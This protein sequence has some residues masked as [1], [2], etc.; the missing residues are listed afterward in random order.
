MALG[1]NGE[2]LRK[3]P[4]ESVLS[5]VARGSPNCC[6]SNR[7]AVH[8]WQLS[9]DVIFGKAHLFRSMELEHLPSH[10]AW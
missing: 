1:Q 9:F 3:N 7:S 5:T 4:Y 8:E 10:V 2:A 6:P